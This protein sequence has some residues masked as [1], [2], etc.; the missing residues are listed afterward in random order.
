MTYSAVYFFTEFGAQLL[1]PKT[2]TDVDKIKLEYLGFCAWKLF[3]T[4]GALLPGNPHLGVG[5]IMN[6]NFAF[7]SKG[8][9]KA[10]GVSPEKYVVK[11]LNYLIKIILYKKIQRIDTFKTNLIINK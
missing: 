7:S 10:F 2:Y 6:M 8:A 1:D 4:N 9:A 3:K 11:F 5:R